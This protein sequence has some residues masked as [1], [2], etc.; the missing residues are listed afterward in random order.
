[1]NTLPDI[2]TELD[3]NIYENNFVE[4]INDFSPNG[5]YG[6]MFSG[7][8]FRGRKPSIWIF[9]SIISSEDNIKFLCENVIKK[10]TNQYNYPKIE[11]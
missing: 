10:R 9:T 4:F 3:G 7:F 11:Y 6:F 1:M 8:G 2:Y 5:K